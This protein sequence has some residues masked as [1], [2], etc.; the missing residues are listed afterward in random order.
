M[1]DGVPTDRGEG[2]RDAAPFLN[3]DLRGTPCPLNYVRCR[4]ALEKIPVGACLR[5]RLDAGEPERMVSEG[6]RD[7]GHEVTLG[8]PAGSLQEGGVLLSIR[9][10]GY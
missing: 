2:N 7:E 6:L 8:D 3:L 5:V 10:G 4:L 9:R 1:A